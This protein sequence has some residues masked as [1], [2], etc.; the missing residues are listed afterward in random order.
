MGL[1]RLGIETEK[2]TTN[3]D[4]L[5][6]RISALRDSMK[7]A[8]DDE[9]AAI[10]T[11]I[12]ALEA[13]KAD[14]KA[15]D[16]RAQGLSNIAK[17]QQNFKGQAEAYGATTAGAMDKLGVAVENLQEKWGAKLLPVV[18]KVATWLA[19]PGI[20]HFD[21][22]VQRAIKGAEELVAWYKENLAPTIK[23]AV[24]IAM[25]FWDKFGD[26]I[27]RNV[28]AGLRILKGLV[29]FITGVFT[30]D[31]DRAWKG[32]KNMFGGFVDYIINQVDIIKKVFRL[33]GG[34]L[35]D[36]LGKGLSGLGGLI[37]D[38]FKGAVNE[39]IK[40][41]NRGFNI[42]RNNWPDI[43]GA[44]GPPWGNDPIPKLARGG[45]V[46]RPGMFIAGENGPR[47]T[48][49]VVTDAPQ[50]RKKNI[51][52]W[53]QAG[54]ALGVPGFAEG[55][56][57]GRA[58]SIAAGIDA[59]NYPYA[60]GGGRPGPGPSYGPR[61]SDG[62]GGTRF[63]Y[64][65]SGAV[66]SVVRQAGLHPPG[67]IFSGAFDSWGEPGHPGDR[68][69]LTYSNNKHV[70][71]VIDGV[72]YGTGAGPD[73]G[74]GRLPYNHRSGFTIRRAPYSWL[75]QTRTQAGSGQEEASASAGGPGQWVSSR[76]TGNDQAGGTA[77]RGTQGPGGISP[78]APGDQPPAG[79]GSAG[80]TVR[81]PIAPPVSTGSWG[82]EHRGGPARPGETQKGPKDLPQPPPPPPPFVLAE[83]DPMLRLWW[84]QAQDTPEL[85]DDIQAAANYVA[86]WE[87]EVARAAAAG[88]VAGE[89][90]AR[91]NAR[92]WR[93][94]LDSLRQQ[95]AGPKPGDL[96]SAQLA[97]ANAR[98]TQAIRFGRASE[99]FIRTG[100]Q[101]GGLGLGLGFGPTVN[102][103]INTLHP[104]D[105]AVHQ[106]VA[107][108]ALSGFALQ[109]PITSSLVK[110]G[111]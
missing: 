6:E 87:R 29:Q 21:K 30:G 38:A 3:Q 43:P 91:S 110:T 54:H 77:G 1:K 18:T 99:S 13:T 70:F 68:G 40:I 101:S 98:A 72:G 89:S 46:T 22:F 62:S 107:Q 27:I 83:E 71:M 23:R 53:A 80:T 11:K 16:A 73:G 49:W 65:C 52:Y 45:K 61:H 39:G 48:E 85:A 94:T 109:S 86:F 58:A 96:S 88:D 44:P 64:D 66:H 67:S 36:M 12:A 4:K 90:Q 106:A 102:V 55:G 20:E 97:Q 15:M 57:V 69:V 95:A 84:E 31:W 28:Q 41:L 34:Q 50:H 76:G 47:E 60:W 74:F 51:A 81:G 75:G 79:S 92:G 33:L 32:L 59:H 42:V 5:K 8:D 104:G 56:I 63:G 111:L 19:G 100:G 2:V 78:L 7:G 26:N 35:K 105:P 10:Q 14:A 24:E 108:A 103:S 9:K 17:L 82:E 37:S 93:Q 25:A